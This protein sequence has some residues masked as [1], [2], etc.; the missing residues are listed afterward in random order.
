MSRIAPSASTE[1]SVLVK[2]GRRCAICFGLHSDTRVQKGQIAH[3][4]QDPSNSTETNLLFLCLL[5]HDEYDSRTS[6]A[7]GLT[8]E[9]VRHYRQ[10]LYG[11]VEQQRGVVW[12]DLPKQD[13][14]IDT[15]MHLMPPPSDL[16]RRRLRIY[17]A[18]RRLIA[19]VVQHATVELNDLFRFV[20]VTDEAAFLFDETVEDTLTDLY[21][22][23]VRLRYT[24]E[25]LF[26]GSLPI[27][28]ERHDLAEENGNL[29]LWFTEQ[30]T[31]LR[32]RLKPFLQVR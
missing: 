23:G 30:F 14:R 31:E 3:L 4:D 7:K 8:M 6:Q 25:Q 26:A 32:E 29:L 1:T 24:H 2:S 27:G 9:E 21:R 17:R 11:F 15:S 16:Y 10:Q 19:T 28:P 20:Q 12:V 13:R 18:A 22:K 5:H